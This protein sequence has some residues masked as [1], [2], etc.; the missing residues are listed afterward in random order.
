MQVIKRWGCKSSYEVLRISVVLGFFSAGSYLGRS[1]MNFVQELCHGLPANVEMSLPSCRFSF[2][3]VASYLK[4]LDLSATVTF[5]SSLSIVELSAI[6]C[7]RFGIQFQRGL[8]FP[9]R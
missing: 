6:S 9:T 3:T 7:L 5:S 8:D 1:A 2:P 4:L